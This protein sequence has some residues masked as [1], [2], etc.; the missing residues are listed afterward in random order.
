MNAGDPD[1]LCEL[2][3]MP[4]TMRSSLCRQHGTV[5]RAN[6]GTC[7]HQLFRL[8][9]CWLLFKRLDIQRCAHPAQGSY[10]RAAQEVSKTS[11]GTLF[12]AC[13]RNEA[14]RVPVTN[15]KSIKGLAW[16]SWLA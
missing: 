4:T 12:R 9:R 1:R 3:K 5:L 13:G 14:D 7:N 16:S 2:G 11:F 15:L 8:L 6:I 10:T